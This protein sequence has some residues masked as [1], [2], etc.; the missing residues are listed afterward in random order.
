MVKLQSTVAACVHARLHKSEWIDFESINTIALKSARDL[1]FRWFPGGRV[2]GR[3][4]QV[5]NLRGDRGDSLSV[6][7]TKGCWIDF[8]RPADRGSDLVALAAARLNLTQ[9]EAAKLLCAELGI[10]VPSK[11]FPAKR[12]RA[13]PNVQRMGEPSF[14][15]PELSDEQRRNI[16]LAL[17]MWSERLALNDSPAWS[18]LH[19]RGVSVGKDIEDLAFHPRCPL[20]NSTAPA[21]LALLRDACTLEPVGVHRTFIRLD[22]SGKAG[23]LSKPKMTLGRAKNAIIALTPSKDVTLGLGIAEGIENALTILSQGWAPIWACR[24]AGGIGC[25]PVLGGIEELTIFGD[26]DP[27]GLDGA[28]DCAIRW[29]DTGKAVTVHLPHSGA[30]DWNDVHLRGLQHD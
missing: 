4:F 19:N 18:Y 5:G 13:A 15:S 22:G 2:Q 16:S 28:R 23:G 12:R 24:S 25:L 17:R 8:A 14:R 6:S 21:M 30:G 11:T 20:G 26:R 1:L 29:T 3:E 9:P 10:L 27:A 7:L